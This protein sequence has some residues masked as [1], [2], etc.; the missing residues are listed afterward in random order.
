MCQVRWTD[1]YPQLEGRQAASLCYYRRQGNDCDFRSNYLEVYEG[2]IADYL[3][4]FRIPPDYREPIMALYRQTQDE[5]DEAE[6]RRRSLEM[7]LD[8][9]AELYKWGDIDR[10]EYQR[11]REQLAAELRALAPAV[12]LPAMLDQAA[13]FLADVRAAWKAANQEQR[14]RLARLLFERVEINDSR[15]EAIIPQPDFAPFFVLDCQGRG[16]SCGSDGIRTRDLHL[17]RVAC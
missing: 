17:D 9:I 13:A 16:L 11:E 8:R 5:R 6:S 15:V 12:D 4:T 2:Q 3:E 7:R 14:N 10:D 1:S